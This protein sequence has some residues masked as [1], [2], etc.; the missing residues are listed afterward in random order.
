MSPIIG[1]IAAAGIIKGILALLTLPQLGSLLSVKS[2]A[3]ITTSAIADS[4]FFFLPILVGYCAAKRLNSDPIIAAVIG[5]VLVYPQLVDWG[6]AFKTMFEVGG[7][8]FEFLNYTYSI[9]TFLSKPCS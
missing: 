4:A 8:Q 6:K 2:I 9:F 7:I 3:Y 5:G 1:V